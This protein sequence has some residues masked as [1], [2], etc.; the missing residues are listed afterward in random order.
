MPSSPADNWS[1]LELGGQLS[2]RLFGVDAGEGAPV[3]PTPAAPTFRVPGGDEPPR[4]SPAPFAAVLAPAAATAPRAAAPERPPAAP[5]GPFAAASTAPALGA[6]PAAPAVAAGP[7]VTAVTE[8]PLPDLR[9]DWQGLANWCLATLGAEAVVLVDRRGLIL[10]AAGVG[11]VRQL[12]GTG[13]RLLYVLEQCDAFGR[14]TS[15]SVDIELTGVR[16]YSTR[17]TTADGIALTLAVS[18]R[19]E[20]P[21]RARARAAQAVA[22]FKRD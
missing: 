9:G 1:D 16:L 8:A 19:S 7:S 12:Q 11:A 6:L 20:L 21:A 13:A 15:R 4:P 14:G 22:A 10:A 3:G 17:V 5:V 18:S 2:R